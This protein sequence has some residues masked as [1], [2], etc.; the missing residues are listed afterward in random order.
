[1]KLFSFGYDY[2]RWA[3]GLKLSRNLISKLTNIRSIKTSG[4][5]QVSSKIHV[6][7]GNNTKELLRNIIAKKIVIKVGLDGDYK[8]STNITQTMFN[9]MSTFIHVSGI[10]PVVQEAGT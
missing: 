9:T 8:P 6:A 1:M 5:H 4:R 3:F 10:F 2:G 7:D